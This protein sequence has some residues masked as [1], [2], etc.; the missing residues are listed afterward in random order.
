M[1][2]A[3]ARAALVKVKPLDELEGKS[4]GKTLEKGFLPIRYLKVSC[5]SMYGTLR[6]K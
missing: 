1:A 5:P 2:L 3:R 6:S 4:V